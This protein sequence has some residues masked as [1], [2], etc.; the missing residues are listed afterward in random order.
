[1][2]ASAAAVVASPSMVRRVAPREPALAPARSSPRA[3][4]TT[5][6]DAPAPRDAGDTFAVARDAPARPA[7]PVVVDDLAAA[8]AAANAPHF[9]AY[10]WILDAPPIRP[11]AVDTVLPRLRTAGLPL[12]D[13]I[14]AALAARYAAR[15]AAP[16]P[17]LQDDVHADRAGPALVIDLHRR[18]LASDPYVASRIADKTTG[19][20]DHLHAELC[21]ARAVDLA[22]RAGLAPDTIELVRLAAHVHDS[23]RSFPALMTQGEDQAR[24]DPA[25]YR[26]FKARHMERSVARAGDLVELARSAGARFSD[27][28][29][30]DL[31]EL[32]GRHELGG[33][34][35]PGVVADRAAKTDPRVSIDALADLV[36]D[37]DSLSFFDA[38]VLTY[39]HE[40]GRDE[41]KLAAKAR[42][43]FDRMSPAAQALVRSDVLGDDASP[44]GPR[45]AGRSETLGAIRDV[46]VRALTQR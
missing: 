38:N 14:A 6:R 28:F 22:Q 18:M 40:V 23:D 3:T 41:G 5:A 15:I 9:A 19:T 8:D 35:V 32:V 25:A 39:W 29:V 42:Y 2:G 4:A 27:S 11:G 20:L 13:E 24:G 17:P 44:L 31:V 7:R 21:A 33:R 30:A 26:A 16:I 46:V 12:D 1:M 37:A 43:M 36:R 10:A 34:A 45:A